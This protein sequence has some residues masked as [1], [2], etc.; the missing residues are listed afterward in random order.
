MHTLH[1]IKQTKITFTKQTLIH[2]PTL[3]LTFLTGN[4]MVLF[5]LDIKASAEEHKLPSFV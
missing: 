3:N 4:I 5:D 1:Y 2:N